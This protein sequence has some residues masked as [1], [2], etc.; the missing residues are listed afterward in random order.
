[1]AVC[2]VLLYC[3]LSQAQIAPLRNLL[4]DH[5]KPV[6]RG[7]V[8]AR[9]APTSPK[10]CPRCRAPP[11]PN[12]DATERRRQRVRPP[13]P[14]LPGPLAPRPSMPA[15]C[16]KKRARKGRGKLEVPWGHR[17]TSRDLTQVLHARF[18][19]RARSTAGTQ[20]P[21]HPRCPANLRPVPGRPTQRAHARTT[22]SCRRV[23]LR[24]LI[25]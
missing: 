18:P 9:A 11:P 16:E 6:S 24:L 14:S 3:E 8:Q 12:A 5:Q 15:G 25:G 21:A 19:R 1:M 13:R 4:R 23:G 17:P 2:L 10:P 7:Q 20:S 22:R